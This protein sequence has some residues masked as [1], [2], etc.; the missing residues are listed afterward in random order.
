MNDQY[1][2]KKP[3]AYVGHLAEVNKTNHVIATEN[4]YNEKGALLVPKG[5]KISPNIAAKV[6][7]HKLNKPL[8]NSVNLEKNKRGKD[9]YNDMRRLSKEFPDFLAI[10]YYMNI[11]ESL[12]KFCQ[13]YDKLPIIQQ[14]VTVLSERMPNEYHKGLFCSWLG[15]CIATHMNLKT[16]SLH[17][18]FI[19]G[20]IHDI[21]ML[22]IE[23]E[24]LKKQGDLSADEWR[25]IQSHVVIVKIMLEGMKGLPKLTAT[26]V[27]EHH[28]RCDGAGYPRALTGDKLSLEGQVVAICDS[29]FSIR[30]KQLAKNNLSLREIVPIIQVNNTVHFYQTYEAVVTMIRRCKIP[31]KR[32]IDDKKI[33]LFGNNL[34]DDCKKLRTQFCSI[35]KFINSVS[36][37]DTNSK[38]VKVV[39]NQIHRLKVSLAGSG[40]ISPELMTWISKVINEK[41]TDSFNE[42]EEV[43]LI[44]SELIYQF[45]DLKKILGLC[46]ADD[47]KTEL[48]ICDA[49][50]ELLAELD[51]DLSNSSTKSHKTIANAI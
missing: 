49:I 40:V 6:I 22:H 31:R 26:A 28:E 51:K 24:I 36:G 33:S 7:K 11:D 4:I 50:K 3:D 39:F 8:E 10:H 12:K 34:L 25:A 27:L 42:V 47:A 14:K 21:G 18:V 15:L 13:M 43:S 23:P 48:P 37:I 38:A 46:L 32:F 2:P 9:L 35:Q 1:D 20:L 30:T 45:K 29:I 17:T 19:A 44:V 41:R 5:S 16:E